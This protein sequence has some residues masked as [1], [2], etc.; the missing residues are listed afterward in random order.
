MKTYTFHQWVDIFKPECIP[1]ARRSLKKDLKYYKEK[2]SD[3]SWVESYQ[4]NRIN[5]ADF[6]DQPELI[7]EVENDVEEIYKGWDSK[8]KG[9][10]FRLAYLDELQGKAPPRKMGGV[11]ESDIERAKE[12]PIE[13][14]YTDTLRSRGRT[15]VGRCPFHG[16]KTASF[17][18]YTEQ[19]SWYCYGAC[20]EGGSVIDFVM[21]LQGIDFLSA[22]KVLLK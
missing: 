17:T 19:N 20:G 11:N 18:I 5:K 7:R 4:N 14:F 16:E 9:I 15:S 2:R 22:V 3:S 13:E 1:P 6:R 10:V 21:K 12:I 8:I